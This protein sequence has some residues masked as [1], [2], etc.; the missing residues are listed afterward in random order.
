MVPA[1]CPGIVDRDIRKQPMTRWQ[2]FVKEAER[3][4]DATEY[5]LL[6]AL[7]A[8]ALIVGAAV[9]GGKIDWATTLASGR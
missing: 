3:G 1:Y 8:V 5:A 2:R 9:L 4:A 7:I 6:A